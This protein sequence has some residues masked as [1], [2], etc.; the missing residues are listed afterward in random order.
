MI[1]VRWFALFIGMAF[2]VGCGSGS[3][4]VGDTSRKITWEEYQK[5]DPEE[6]DDPY[7]LDNLDDEAKQKLAGP[8]KRR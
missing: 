8:S 2:L 1:R 6:K 4:P 7:V 3:G 5:M